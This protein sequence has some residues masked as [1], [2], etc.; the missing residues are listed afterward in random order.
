VISRLLAGLAAALFLCQPW[1]AAAFAQTPEDIFHRGNAAYEQGRYADAVEAYRSLLRYDV[2]D[3]IVEYNLANAEFRVGNLGRAI[4]HYERA[5][6]LD[7]TDPDI[8]NNLE[9]ARSRCFDRVETPRQAAVARWLR[10][11]QNRLGPDRQAWVAVATVWLIA[12]LFAWCLSRPGGWTARHG[13]VLAVLLVAMVA[14]VSS[15]YVTLDRLDGR[16]SAVVLVEVAEVLAGPGYSNPTLFTVHEG[17]TLEIRAEREDWLQVSL[18]N[19]LNGWIAR[20][21]VDEV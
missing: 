16:R 9:F 11:L 4:L 14:A 7:P 18:P 5:R 17:L 15:W 8:Q 2:R 10:A 1:C 19:G 3:P 21:S 20:R 13:W 12:A 6:R